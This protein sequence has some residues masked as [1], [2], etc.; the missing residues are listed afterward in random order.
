VWGEANNIPSNKSIGDELVAGENRSKRYPMYPL[1]LWSETKRE[2]ISEKQAA[3]VW[4]EREVL[5]A[6]SSCRANG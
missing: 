5:Q 4:G 1:W 3:R 6:P 2:R